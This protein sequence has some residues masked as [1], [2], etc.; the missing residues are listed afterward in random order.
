MKS[1]TKGTY[2]GRCQR[3]L[4]GTRVAQGKVAFR[5]RLTEHWHARC[6]YVYEHSA[7]V[8]L[9]ALSYE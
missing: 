5:K 6:Y 7:R 4:K 2:V 8:T 1:N 9:S 3:V